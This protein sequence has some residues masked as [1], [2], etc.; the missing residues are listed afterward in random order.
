M[1]AEE[2]IQLLRQPA[3]LTPND[4]E[5]AGDL[6][7]SHPYFGPAACLYLKGLYDAKDMRLAATLPLAALSVPDRRRLQAWL[8]TPAFG[9]AVS[10]D[11]PLGQA[12]GNGPKMKHSDLIDQFI[13]TDPRISPVGEQD[14]EPAVLPSEPVK[15]ATDSVFTESLAKIY[16]KQGQYAKAIRIFEKLNLKYPEKSAYFADQIASLQ[17]KTE[18]NS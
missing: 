3:L 18:T 6:W 15:P 8:E 11:Y 7:K 4:R 1:T 12:S 14:P 5:A 17:K 16:I 10:Q 13:K 2:F 9:S